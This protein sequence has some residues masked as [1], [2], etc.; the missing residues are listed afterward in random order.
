MSYTAESG[1]LLLDVG[2]ISMGELTQ[3]IEQVVRILENALIESGRLRLVPVAEADAETIAF[4][5]TLSKPVE[6]L[7]LSSVITDCI[8]V[9]YPTSAGPVRYV[10]E[11]VQRSEV[12]MLKTKN[13]GSARFRQV[14]LALTELGLHFGMTEAD[15]RGWTPPGA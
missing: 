5:A 4:W 8:K 14:K 11:L 12:D 13:V 9:A 7:G 6:E 2:A 1:Q 15:L 10:G 3:I